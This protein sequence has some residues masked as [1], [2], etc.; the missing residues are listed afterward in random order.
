MEYLS[1]NL[2]IQTLFLFLAIAGLINIFY[3]FTIRK[4]LNKKDVELELNKFEENLIE[5]L[6]F[7]KQLEDL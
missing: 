3:P 2:W 4:E 5:D 1:E 7:K 6:E